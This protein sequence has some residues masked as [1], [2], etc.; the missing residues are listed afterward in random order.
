MFNPYDVRKRTLNP[1][2]LLHQRS[3]T[4]TYLRPL[5]AL[6][7]NVGTAVRLPPHARGG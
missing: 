7:V 2:V 6:V 4:A 1:W 3:L 5:E